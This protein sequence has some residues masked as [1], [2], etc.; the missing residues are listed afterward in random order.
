MYRAFCRILLYLSNKC[1]VYIKNIFLDSDV[2]HPHC[3][4]Y[5]SKELNV[6]IHTV[7]HNYI[8]SVITMRVLQRHVS[9]LHVGHLHTN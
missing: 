1:T 6:V 5:N 4:L 9:A 7:K 3:V 2:R 8:T